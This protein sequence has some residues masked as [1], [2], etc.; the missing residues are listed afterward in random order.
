M[1]YEEEDF[2]AL[3]RDLNRYESLRLTRKDPAAIEVIDDAIQHAKRRL[4]LLET[5]GHFA[6]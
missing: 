5:P 1:C 4:R 3:R 6:D 2:I